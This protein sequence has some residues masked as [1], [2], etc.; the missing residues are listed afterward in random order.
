MAQALGLEAAVALLNLTLDEENLAAAKIKS[1]AE[2]IFAK[3]AEEPEKPE[4]LKSGKE[5]YSAKKSI[6]DEKKAAPD[7]KKR[8][9]S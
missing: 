9:A 2:P 6:E 4:K 7:L 1:A 3:S 5:K 8:K